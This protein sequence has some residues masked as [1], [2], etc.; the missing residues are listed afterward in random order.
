[1][2]E[3]NLALHLKQAIQKVATGPEYSKDLSYTEAYQAMQHIL[4]GQ[5]DPVQTAI[6][7]IALRMKRETDEENRGTLQALMDNSTISQAAVD[8]LVDISDP[9]DG[10]IRGVP[11]SSFVPAVLAA[12]GVPAVLHGVAQV[13]PKYGATHHKVLQAAG[14]KVQLSPAEATQQLEQIGWTYVDQA[15][16]APSLHALIP[17]RQRMIKRQ[18]LTTV[19]TMLGPIRAR[20]KTHC[21]GG[22]VHKAYPPIYAS[23]ARQAGFHSALFVRGVEG[24]IIPS[25]QQAGRLFAYQAQGAE[26]QVDLVPQDLGIVAATRAV[27]LPSALVPA[28][29]TPIDSDALAAQAAQLGQ[30]ALAGER[31]LTYDSLVYASAICLSH[32]KRYPDLQTAATAVR[33]V[34][35]SGQALT[36]FEA[37]KHSF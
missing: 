4:T 30:A 10:F 16:F 27:P 14:V 2:S 9:Y 29:D 36:V 18:V 26:Y 6:Y 8:E 7:L 34:L 37:A 20:L 1:M 12:M 11:A 3:L 25:L 28:E 31:G 15:S 32:L 21:M 23:L 17:L 24:G 33:T 13:G 5:A 19:E 35:D 22:Y